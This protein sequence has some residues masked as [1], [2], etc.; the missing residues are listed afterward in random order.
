MNGADNLFVGNWTYRSLRNNPD[1]NT[2]FNGLE[3]GRGVLVIEPAA[4]DELVG[5]IGGPGWSLALHGSRGYGS[6]MSVRF[7][8]NGIVGGQEWIYD[9]IG[10]LVPVWPTVLRPSSV[11]P[12]SARWCAPYNMAPRRPVWSL[13]STRCTTISDRWPGR[14]ALAT[15]EQALLDASGASGCGCGCSASAARW[16][17]GKHLPL[18]PV[19]ALVLLP[20]CPLCLMAWFGIFGSLEVSSWVSDLWGT[21]LAIGLLSFAIVALVLRAWRSGNGNPLV[22]G[23]LG[24]GAML[25]GKCLFAAPPLLYAGLGL[26]IGASIWSVRPLDGGAALRASNLDSPEDALWEQRSIWFG[27]PPNLEPETRQRKEARC[28]TPE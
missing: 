5:T 16:G 11:R 27:E 3:F 18:L 1:I 24:A 10:W 2:A 20:K 14:D 19:I 9:Y 7:Q 28:P 21:P 12:S 26:L 4:F 13:R 8:G 25:A 22:I 6:P 15:T 23:L 17:T